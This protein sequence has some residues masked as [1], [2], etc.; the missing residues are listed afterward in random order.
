[1]RTEI[2]E[3]CAK[4]T[5]MAPLP[6]IGCRGALSSLWA[7]KEAKGLGIIQDGAIEISAPVL[8]EA[9]PIGVRRAEGPISYSNT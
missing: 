9:C 5:R 6:A 2:G 1:M 8:G 4:L 7:R 3:S